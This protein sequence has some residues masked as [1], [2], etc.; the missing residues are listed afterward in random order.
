MSNVT[1][2]CYDANTD[3]YLV[4]AASAC[5]FCGAITVEESTSVVDRSK[6]DLAKSLAFYDEGLPPFKLH[7]RCSR[8]S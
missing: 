1:H 3:E 5:H 6:A 2:F 4:F 8:C 7:T